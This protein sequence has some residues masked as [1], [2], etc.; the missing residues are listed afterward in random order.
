M[1]GLVFKEAS[2]PEE[3]LQIEQ[4][5]HQTFA[6]EIAQHALRE[7]GRLPDRFH[8]TNH[9]FI[10]KRDGV[11][12]GMISANTTPPFSTEKRLPSN[13]AVYQFGNRPCEIRL[14]SV[15]QNARGGM[16]L[17][18]LF[19]KVYEF[20]KRE[21]CS[22]LVISGVLERVPMYESL[23]F[24]AMGPAVEDGKA[25]FVPMELPLTALPEKTL[26]RIPMFQ[27]WWKQMGSDHA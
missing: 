14:L 23:G 17:A 6:V 24:R 10:A 2:S 13:D 16:V 12:L 7:D 5:N 1:P 21:S 3:I 20:A 8:A 11:L 26:H 18:G 4:L 25:S 27:R 19:W 22:H 9:Y 15:R